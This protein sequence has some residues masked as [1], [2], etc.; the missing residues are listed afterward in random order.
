MAVYTITGH[1]LNYA[2]AGLDGQEADLVRHNPTGSSVTINLTG[3]KDS[4][5]KGHGA[6]R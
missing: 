1:P 5:A 4:K 2:E 3:P 6:L